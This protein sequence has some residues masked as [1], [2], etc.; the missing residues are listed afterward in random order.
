MHSFMNEMLGGPGNKEARERIW[1]LWEVRLFP[2]PLSY[3][4]S[5]NLIMALCFAMHS[6]EI[7]VRSTGNS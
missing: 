2:A 4:G 5:I 1:S 3:F 6:A 7:G